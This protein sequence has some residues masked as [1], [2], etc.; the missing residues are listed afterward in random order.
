MN[1]FDPAMERPH[2]YNSSD[3]YEASTYRLRSRKI[4]SIPFVISDNLDGH[5]GHP[6]TLDLYSSRKIV[7]R[8][9]QDLKHTHRATK[10]ED[11]TKKGPIEKYRTKQ[12]SRK[13]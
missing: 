8:C 12:K 3:S 13:K 7:H 10:H 9:S 5:L 1:H 6:T 11:M 4:T 2:I